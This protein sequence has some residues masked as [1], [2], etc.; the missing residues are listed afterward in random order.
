MPFG[1][2]GAG[3][4]GLAGSA[5]PVGGVAG[6][7]LLPVEVGVDPGA[8][9]GVDVLGGF[10]GCGPVALGVVP[11]GLQERREMRGLLG[12]ELAE[13]FGGDRRH[14]RLDVGTLP[15]PLLFV[16]VFNSETLALDFGEVCPFWVIRCGVCFSAYFSLVIQG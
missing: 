1:G 9:G 2:E 7:T 8:V 10:V 6:V 5:V 13:V 11:E 14:G 15:S 4:G 16:K 3:G 12:W